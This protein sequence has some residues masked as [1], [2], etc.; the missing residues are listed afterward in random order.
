M[1]IHMDGYGKILLERSV[2]IKNFKSRFSYCNYQYEPLVEDLNW[3]PS[4]FNPDDYETDSYPKNA[5]TGIKKSLN[6]DDIPALISTEIT[7]KSTTYGEVC[8]GYLKDTSKYAIN[9]DF[10][11]VVYD[12]FM[13]LR[14]LFDKGYQIVV[15]KPEESEKKISLGEGVYWGVVAFDGG[16][17]F[18]HMIRDS[19]PK[20]YD[21]N[22]Q[23]YGVKF[24]VIDNLGHEL[25]VGRVDMVYKDGEEV[26]VSFTADVDAITAM[27]LHKDN[28]LYG[29]RAYTDEVKEFI[30]GDRYK[31]KMVDAILGLLGILKDGGQDAPL[32]SNFNKI[33]LDVVASV[34]MVREINSEELLSVIT[35]IMKGMGMYNTEVLGDLFEAIMIECNEIVK[36]ASNMNYVPSRSPKTLFDL[37]LDKELRSQG[38]TPIKR[39]IKKPQV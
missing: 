8:T 26:G 29:S 13:Y 25:E 20:T 36:K 6:T 23:G 10:S 35:N 14:G 30:D 38:K 39:V 4:R 5:V 1:I 15:V 12:F 31:E 34:V 21:Q 2:A 32:L 9:G 22:H 28:A 27:R 37:S 24:K 33:Y 18:S 11:T 3:S 19:V 7:K 17:F 16:F